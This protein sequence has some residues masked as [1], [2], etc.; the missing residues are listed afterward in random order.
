MDFMNLLPDY[1]DHNLTMQTIQRII[2]LEA[3]ALDEG[4]KNTVRQC[5]ISTATDLLA[6]YEVIFG[7]EVNCEKPVS[8]RRERILAKAV[9][10]GTT[11]KSMIREVAA[12]YS[13]GEVEIMEDNA[14]H[15]IVVRF[16]GTIGIPGN[17]NDLK[18]TLEEIKPAHLELVYEYIYNTHDTFNNITH[19]TMSR[20]T[21][22]QLRNEEMDYVN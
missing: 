11:T 8:Y 18:A 22:W 13:N 12:A 20:S 7:L 5:F 14:N 3:E 16:V 15:K 4:L 21:H 1:Y 17:M 9:G 19:K 10:N 6:R 2:S